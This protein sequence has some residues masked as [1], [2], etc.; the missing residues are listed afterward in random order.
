MRLKIAV[1][2]VSAV[3]LKLQGLVEQ[4][5]ALPVP[6]KPEND[7]PDAGAAVQ[8]TAVPDVTVLTPSAQCSPE[9]EPEPVPAVVIVSE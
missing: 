7:E 6:E 1:R 5:D 9:T 3:T 4:L 2:V 8:V